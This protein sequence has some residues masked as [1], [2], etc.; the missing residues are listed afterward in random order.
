MLNI[1]LFGELNI[2]LMSDQW[3]VL[4]YE[5]KNISME[6][7]RLVKKKKGLFAS[8]KSCQFDDFLLF[9]KPNSSYFVEIDSEF[10]G[11]NHV[12]KPAGA[13]SFKSRNMDIPLVQYRENDSSGF[14]VETTLDFER[15][16]DQILNPIEEDS[17]LIEL[18]KS[19]IDSL[20]LLALEALEL[21][22]V[23]EEK[24]AQMKEQ[25]LEY[26][27]LMKA[28]NKLDQN[29]QPI[30]HVGMEEGGMKD[31]R[32]VYNIRA[33]FSYDFIEEEGIKADLVHY[34]P[35]A[36]QLEKS[37]AAS[38]TAFAMKKSLK[39][40]LAEYFEPGSTVKIRIIGSADARANVIGLEY[41]GEYGNIKQ[42]QYFVAE[43]YQIVITKNP[44]IDSTYIQERNG[45][46]LLEMVAESP[47]A[48]R[49][50]QPRSIDLQTKDTF[51]E[52]EVLAFL[53]SQGVR[54]YILRE[55]EELK[56]TKNEF[57]H[58]A[59]IEEEI[60][61]K[62]RKVVIEILIEDVVRAK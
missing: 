20:R 38:A 8:S 10:C 27:E 31:G 22:K 42:Q 35:G 37:A 12:E 17:S 24:E 48:V 11:I 60:G 13:A 26:F 55:V 52:N 18:S 16:I 1:K 33:S 23:L 44:E 59:K 54:E 46:E 6:I 25:L 57:T 41:K 49:L 47:E 40:Y 58:Q 30:V 32:M 51:K 5:R 39:N 50:G 19:E 2:E 4:A 56:N 21:R 62:F 36:Y 34:P 29:V 15:K 43:D 3:L 28:I 61:G 53:R 9:S 45:E 7:A 14:T